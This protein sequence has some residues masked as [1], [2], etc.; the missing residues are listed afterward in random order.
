MRRDVGGEV[1]ELCEEHKVGYE[2]GKGCPGCKAGAVQRVK[3]AG[4]WR[5]CDKHGE[6]VYF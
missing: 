6:K 4:S 3:G 5:T 2:K 1:I